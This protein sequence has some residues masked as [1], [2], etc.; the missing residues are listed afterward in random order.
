MRGVRYARVIYS[1][2]VRIRR[3][4]VISHSKGSSDVR[5]KT[6]GFFP[7]HFVRI[8]SNSRTVCPRYAQDDP[9]CP[10]YVR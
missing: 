3:T 8:F 10:C 4:D 1:H 2:H 9:T 6:A 5:V 7:I